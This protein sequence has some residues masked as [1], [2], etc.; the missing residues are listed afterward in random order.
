MDRSSQRDSGVVQGA[1]DFIIRHRG[2]LQRQIFLGGTVL[3]DG[4]GGHDHVS[5][6]DLQVDTAA[7]AQTDQR[8]RSAFHQLL[9]SDGS[10]GPANACGADADLF[11]QQRPRIGGKLPVGRHEAG[12][13]KIPGDALAAAR[14]AGQDHI[15]SDIA[16]LQ[17]RMHLLSF[18][19]H[20]GSSSRKMA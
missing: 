17:G 4:T 6:P 13:V 16:L 20:G 5:A 10:T 18:Y 9:H 11:A 7:G 1:G 19:K 2:K 15:P 8:I 14:V 3:T 12:V